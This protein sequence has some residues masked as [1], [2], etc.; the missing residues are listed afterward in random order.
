MTVS[1]VYPTVCVSA[2]W[3][4]LLYCVCVFHLLRFMWLFYC[5][6][7]ICVWVWLFYGGSGIIKKSKKEEK[8]GGECPWG[9][10]TPRYLR[11]S[12]VAGRT[13]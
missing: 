13:H 7:K 10:E 3:S 1:H 12:S 2:R 5:S 9:L 6:S 4:S 11:A 8:G